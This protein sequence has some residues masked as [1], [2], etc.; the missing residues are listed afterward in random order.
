MAL[1]KMV[2]A[3][4][5]WLWKTGHD[6]TVLK[7]P[8][9]VRFNIQNWQVLGGFWSDEHV[10]VRPADV[11][12]YIERELLKVLS[13]TPTEEAVLRMVARSTHGLSNASIAVCLWPDAWDKESR[14]HGYLSGHASQIT[15]RLVRRGLLVG[16]CVDTNPTQW[17]RDILSLTDEG[18]RTLARLASRQEAHHA[19]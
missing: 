12:T 1:R 2:L 17:S 5:T 11:R 14:S 9:G 3:S 18:K 15:G 16:T 6:C 8:D 13:P 10:I 4:G 19:S 7:S